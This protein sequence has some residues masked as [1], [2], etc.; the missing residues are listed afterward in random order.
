MSDASVCS[1][2]GA[3]RAA[4]RI[5]RRS[6]EARHYRRRRRSATLGVNSIDAASVGVRLF[7]RPT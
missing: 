1:C 7:V 4:A 2:R 5:R 3:T 6:A